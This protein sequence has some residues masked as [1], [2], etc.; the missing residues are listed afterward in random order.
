VLLTGCVDALSCHDRVLFARC[1][2][3]SSVLWN[4]DTLAKFAS[5]ILDL[6]ERGEF[7]NLAFPPNQTPGQFR[8]PVSAVFC[9]SRSSV[10]HPWSLQQWMVAS[11]TTGQSGVTMRGREFIGGR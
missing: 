6:I 7:I 2:G 11:Y 9:P 4:I 3:Y 10:W 5:H 1:V 8:R